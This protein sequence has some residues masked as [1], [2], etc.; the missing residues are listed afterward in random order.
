MNTEIDA[1]WALLTATA[2]DAVAAAPRALAALAVLV[3]AWL[4]ARLARIAIET[5][6]ARIVRR[7]A[8]LDVFVM[9]SGAAVWI[10]ASLIASAIVFPSITPADVLTVL[11][12]GSVAVG[13][14]FKDIF[15]NFFAGLLILIRAPFEI[16]DHINAGEVEGAVERISVRDTRIRRTDGQLVIVPNADLFK[17]AV[18]VRTNQDVRRTSIICG[19]AY[20]ED[21]DHA[22]DVIQ[23][24]VRDVDSVRDDVRDVQVFARRFNES[25]IDFEIAWW[26]G[27]Q[28][29]DVRRSR[30]EVVRAVKRALDAAG[31][32]IPFPQRVLTYAD[33]GAAAQPSADARAHAD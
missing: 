20:G 28:P 11:G 14:A 7:A 9:L 25:S 8:L 26:T 19:V 33:D 16:G 10:A 18:L 1:L 24:A 2:E 4:V 5:L 32:E 30:D 13:F 15:E 27:S 21:V 22:R 3:L 29:L 23:D 31:V 12:L 6:G 17:N